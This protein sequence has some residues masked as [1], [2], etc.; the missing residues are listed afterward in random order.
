MWNL[1]LVWLEFVG[2]PTL[3][4]QSHHTSNAL[5]IAYFSQCSSDKLLKLNELCEEQHFVTSNTCYF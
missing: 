1:Q 3:K 4:K 2:S 5:N